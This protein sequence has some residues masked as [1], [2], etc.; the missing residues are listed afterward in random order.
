MEKEASGFSDFITRLRLGKEFPRLALYQQM[1]GAKQLEQMKKLRTAN[2]V[3]SVLGGA[4]GLT[5]LLSSL[6]VLDMG[7]LTGRGQ[8]RPAMQPPTIIH[9]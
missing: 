4:G 8:E 1:N 9:Y 7:K 6:G 5:M 3:L 2:K